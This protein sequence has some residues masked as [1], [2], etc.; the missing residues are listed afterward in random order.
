M[1]KLKGGVT[2]TLQRKTKPNYR[3]NFAEVRSINVEEREFRIEP[4]SPNECR[5]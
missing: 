5:E 3:R 2:G 4:I 1:E